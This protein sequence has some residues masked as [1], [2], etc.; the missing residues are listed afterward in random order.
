MTAALEGGEWSAA[1]PGRPLT[2]G[3]TRYPLYRMLCGPQGRSGQAENLAPP[4][5]D[6]RTVQL[7]V[8][9][10]TD[11]AATGRPTTLNHMN[12]I[13]TDIVYFYIHINIIWPP[14]SSIFRHIVFR[15]SYR[16]LACCLLCPS[17]AVD[18][19]TQTTFGETNAVR[20][21]PY[22]HL[23]HPSPS[24]SLL[25]RNVHHITLV[26]NNLGY[27]FCYSCPCINK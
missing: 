23:P 26:S 24:P 3:K 22:R 6:P 18:L 16:A 13:H 27:K 17:F 20:R 11:W 14:F 2:P 15:S 7:V 5:F 4:G 1:R 25:G 9:R 19:I 21:I 12:P 10:Y 8:S